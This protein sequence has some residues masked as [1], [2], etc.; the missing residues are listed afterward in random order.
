MIYWHC[1]IIAH[2][3]RLSRGD[4]QTAQTLINSLAGATHVPTVEGQILDFPDLLKRDVYL[5]SVRKYSVFYFKLYTKST[6][7]GGTELRSFHPVKQQLSHA[8][9]YASLHEA[10]PS[11][12][13]T[14][15]F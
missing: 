9:P 8:K 5:A 3:H 12:I 15:W 7:Q 4:F 10:V 2:L 1:S 6:D 13:L 14:Q 11:A